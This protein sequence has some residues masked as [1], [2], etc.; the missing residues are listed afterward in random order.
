MGIASWYLPARYSSITCL[1]RESTS[2]A[3]SA[4]AAELGATHNTQDRTPTTANAFRETLKREK[5]IDAQCLRIKTLR[6]TAPVRT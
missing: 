3:F 2:K 5:Q 4:S 1:L 6:R